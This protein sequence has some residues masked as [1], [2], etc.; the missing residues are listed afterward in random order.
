MGLDFSKVIK[1]FS[2]SLLVY[3]PTF[4]NLNCFGFIALFAHFKVRLHH[5][6]FLDMLKM[7]VQLP[8]P[9]IC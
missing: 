4:I 1:V 8:T 3:R 6:P 2:I 7:E 9:L 5:P